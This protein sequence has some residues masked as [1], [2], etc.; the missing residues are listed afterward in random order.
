M[1]ADHFPRLAVSII[2]G[3]SGG[4]AFLFSAVGL[5]AGLDSMTVRYGLAVLVGYL[6]FI[7]SIRAW[8]AYHR[9]TL[10]LDL[11]PLD[12][13]E[14]PT[15]RGGGGGV[16]PALF[17]GGRSGGGGAGGSWSLGPV[18]TVGDAV[19]SLDADELWY[20]I[21][22]LA[23]AVGGL[24]AVFYVIYAAPI[25]LAEVALDAGLMSTVYRGLRRR[26]SDVGHWSGAVFRRTWQPALALVVFVTLIGVVFDKAA[27]DA[28]SI[29]GVV[30]A[31]WD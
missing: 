22:A 17:T 24:I 25:L 8:I 5:W 20:V 29:G 26:D 3:I 31:L 19:G 14:L 27:P 7:L 9:G 15:P 21:V 11:D 1:A 28:R 2:L 30:R 13:V 18:E 12:V 10:N 4:C 6:A 23:L 16:K